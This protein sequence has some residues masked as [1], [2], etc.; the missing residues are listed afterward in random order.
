[1]NARDHRKRT[2]L[3]VAAEEGEEELII[4]LLE[5]KADSNVADVEGN[6]PLDLAARKLNQSAV[7]ILL[8]LSQSSKKDEAVKKTL[9]KTMESDTVKD[10][11]VGRK[12]GQ[13]SP[14]RYCTPL[15]MNECTCIDNCF[16][17]SL[18]PHDL[19]LSTCAC[20]VVNMF[21]PEK[22]GGKYQFLQHF[23]LNPK[24]KVTYM[25][26]HACNGV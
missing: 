26:H 14:L 16:T 8:E 22:S 17:C 21:K 13:L 3:H 12:F 4:L 11:F 24:L 9:E 15:C 20:S 1:M 6:T 25:H 18:A 5:N 19:P 2:P 23:A 10:D 7:S